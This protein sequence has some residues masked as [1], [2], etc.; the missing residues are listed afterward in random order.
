VPLRALNARILWGI[1]EFS[2][3][4]TQNLGEVSAFPMTES[5][6][7]QQAAQLRDLTAAE[8]ALIQRSLKE[9]AE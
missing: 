4:R 5:E 7:D 3:K 1:P 9:F 2:K 8:L 6:V